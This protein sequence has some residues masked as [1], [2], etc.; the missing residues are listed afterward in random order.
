MHRTSRKQVEKI[1]ECLSHRETGY[2]LIPH[3]FCGKDN[4][5][6]KYSIGRYSRQPEYTDVFGRVITWTSWKYE[7]TILEFV[8]LKK[9]Y[10]Y[11]SNMLSESLRNDKN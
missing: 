2:Q 1:L 9:A 10:E 7:E 5:Y 3:S 4:Y 8:S 11:A 6:Y